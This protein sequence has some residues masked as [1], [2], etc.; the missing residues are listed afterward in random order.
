RRLHRGDARDRARGRERA[1]PGHGCADASGRATPRRGA[2]R[3]Q[4]AAALD[5]ERLMRRRAALA[6][7][8]A[9]V[10]WIPA[11]VDAQN[12]FARELS[13]EQEKEMTAQIAEQIRAQA[14]FVT[15]PAILDYVDS[16]GNSLVKGV[17]PSPFIFRFNVLEDKELNAFTI[18]GG[19]VYLSS[20]VLAQAG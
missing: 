11:P 20:A 19:Y 8:A 9:A 15:D 3:A 4:A 14:K 17:E 1:R 10:L 5:A 2:R 18:G 6:A 7:L 16:I 13:V 12:P